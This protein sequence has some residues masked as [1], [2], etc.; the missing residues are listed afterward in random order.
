MSSQLEKI[1]QALTEIKNLNS[2]AEKEAKLRATD[3]D[4]LIKIEGWTRDISRRV[5]ALEDSEEKS[6]EKQGMRAWQIW[7]LLVGMIP[8]L[9]ALI[10]QVIKLA[11]EK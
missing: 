8:G 6:E 4:K 3:H 1:T 5:E 11:T 2:A 9:I 7:L 10:L